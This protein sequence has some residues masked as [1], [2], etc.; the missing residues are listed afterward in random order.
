MRA[1][2]NR[3]IRHDL[4]LVVADDDLRMQIFLV[5]DDDHCFLPGRLVHF[6]FHR[7]AFDD[8][9]ELHLAGLLGKNRHVI[10]IPLDECVAL[11]DV[12]AILDGND[13]ADDDGVVFQFAPV[14][15]ED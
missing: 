7:H 5:L 10:R 12:R 8:V 9:V 13:S 11:L 4:A 15:G 2:R 3:V 6:L 1:G 14:V